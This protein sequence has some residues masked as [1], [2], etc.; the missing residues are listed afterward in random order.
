MRR[1]DH[2]LRA[3]QITTAIVLAGLIAWCASCSSERAALKASAWPACMAAVGA[4]VGTLAGP[5]GTIAGA[6]IGGG[7]GH[8]IGE[9]AALRSGE[10]TGAGAA[11][12]WRGEAFR[13]AESAGFFE[14]WLR[15]LA[16]I[17]AGWFALRNREHLIAAVRQKSLVPLLHSLVGGPKSRRA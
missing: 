9:N 6:G 1:A 12:A 16:W 17:V 13:Q 8:M 2:G 15:R 7:V 10:L 11:E 3:A 4:G 14:T 5:V